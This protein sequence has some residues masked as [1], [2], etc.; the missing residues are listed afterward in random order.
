MRIKTHLPLS[1][2]QVY[3]QREPEAEKKL[4]AKDPNCYGLGPIRLDKL[5]ITQVAS[6]FNR[7]KGPGHAIQYLFENSACAS[8]EFQK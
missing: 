1:Q 7:L 4:K 5:N 2:L 3:V 6:A 8:I